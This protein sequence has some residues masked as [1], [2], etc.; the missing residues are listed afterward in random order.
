MPRLD[1]M[2]AI[3][4]GG[5]HPI[6]RAMALALAAEGCGVVA[7]CMSPAEL[8]ETA[9][10]AKKLGGVYLPVK[11]DVTRK[12]DIMDVVSKTMRK[13]KRI[14]VLINNAGIALTR[15]LEQTTEREWDR[16]IRTN[17]G[18]M[19]LFTHAVISHMVHQESGVIINISSAEGRHSIAGV[20]AYSTS[21]FGVIGFT[22]SLAEEVAEDDMRVY[23]IWAQ[24]THPKAY[25]RSRS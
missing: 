23:A 15:P 21:K 8:K 10:A 7:C 9:A 22:E 1:G 18:G 17:L 12:E 3:I 5:S 20:T 19:F 4:T 24:I 25:G 2:S 14:D 16:I 13:F 6:G 11:A